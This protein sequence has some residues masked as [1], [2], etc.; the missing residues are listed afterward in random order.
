MKIDF[1]GRTW[2][3]DADAITLKQGVA[4]H[5]AYGMTVLEMLDG[6]RILDK[7]PDGD[8]TVR[9]YGG[10]RPLDSRSLHCLYWLM[11]QQDGQRKALADADAN[12]V[13]LMTAY[14][15]GLKAEVEAQA[16]AGQPDP[17]PDVVPTSPPP[18]D[19]PWPGHGYQTDT[20]P[21]PS[22]PQHAAQHGPTG[23]SPSP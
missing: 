8:G 10:T 15:E 3:F 1:E 18:G 2:E 20:T 14:M 17:E 19:R 5:M 12:V 16:A 9:D 7:P 21:Q 11:L 23:Y 4:I 13:N 22:G 6:L